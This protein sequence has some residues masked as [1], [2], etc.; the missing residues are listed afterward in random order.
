MYPN[1]N[2][3]RQQQIFQVWIRPVRPEQAHF[4][5][6]LAVYE[7]NKLVDQGMTQED[8]AATRNYLKKF[9]NLLVSSQSR[10]LGYA[11]DSRYY[12]IPEFTRFVNDELD[13][14]TLEKVNS[15]IK[16]QIQTQNIKF[17]FISADA[18]DL[19]YRLINNTSS[20]ISYDADKPQELIDEDEI[21]QDYFLK[22]E[23]EKIRIRSI[24]D[25]FGE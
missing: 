24:E 5:T 12:G 22:F 10:Q 20:P 8:F 17:V 19:K 18:E 14:L 3:G 13:R 1:P 15:V 6:R 9:V 25:M 2:L 16:T 7:L 23:D 4:A 11:L 21:I